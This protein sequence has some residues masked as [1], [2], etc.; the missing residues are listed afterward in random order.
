MLPATERQGRGAF[1]PWRMGRGT[2]TTRCFP[3]ITGTRGLGA[4]LGSAFAALPKC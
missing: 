3:R 1:G 4:G 2:T